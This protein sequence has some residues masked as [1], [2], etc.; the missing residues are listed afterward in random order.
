M[1]KEERQALLE[2]LMEKEI[3]KMRRVV[4]KYNR[5]PL[6]YNPVTILESSDLEE[7][8]GG[9]IHKDATEEKWI[10]EI[11]S[12]VINDYYKEHSH[13][14][15]TKYYKKQLW[16]TI[17]HE[18]THAWVSE[19]YEH[20]IENATR[21]SSFIFLN[22]L[23]MFNYPSGHKCE[24][25][26]RWNSKNV[27]KCTN[28]AEFDKYVMS[29]HKKFTQLEKAYKWQTFNFNKVEDIEVKLIF[30]YTYNVMGIEKLTCVGSNAIGYKK[31]GVKTTY[32]SKYVTLAVGCMLD[33]D[34]LDKYIDRALM[35][36]ISTYKYCDSNSYVYIGNKIVR[37]EKIEHKV[38]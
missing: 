32:N 22:A 33:I 11:N 20:I 19:N 13:T 21:D 34:K 30:P 27:V 15:V 6:L 38:A 5:E 29:I 18:L 36:D 10:I 35:T 8:I 23:F 14:S 12:S 1:N 31:D 3:K 28:K 2:D 9:R 24:Y 37:E 16:Q 4:K 7:H 25:K 26:W 17:G